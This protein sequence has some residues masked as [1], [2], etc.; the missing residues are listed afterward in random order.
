[1]IELGEH[2]QFIIWGYIG[3]AA[4]TLALTF[5]VLWQ[6]RRVHARLRELE[7]RGIRRRSDGPA[8]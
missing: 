2:A 1:M 3:V 4:G 6:S 8:A 7:S 5:W